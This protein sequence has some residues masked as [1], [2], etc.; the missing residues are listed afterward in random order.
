ML[1]AYS[2]L[3]SVITFSFPISTGG[4][5]IH[6][7]IKITSQL[8]HV[9]IMLK[10]RRS[11]N[12]PVCYFSFYTPHLSN[13]C[14]CFSPASLAPRNFV[15]TVFVHLPKQP[16]SFVTVLKLLHYLGRHLPWSQQ[17][18]KRLRS[19]RAP[20]FVHSHLHPFLNVSFFESTWCVCNF[21]GPL[22]M[23]F[24]QTSRM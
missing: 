6:C 8:S 24:F 11:G 22:E 12:P 7:S 23:L 13:R 5:S 21:R 10:W 19:A 3:C 20:L 18:T 9:P 16:L 4:T 14:F 17:G 15:A 2:F 1:A